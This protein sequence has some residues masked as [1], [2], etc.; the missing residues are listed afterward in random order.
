MAQ[1]APAPGSGNEDFYDAEVVNADAVA[2]EVNPVADKSDVLRAIATLCFSH[3]VGKMLYPHV[4]GHFLKQALPQ[5]LLPASG[6]G[7]G[8]TS[9]QTRMNKRLGIKEVP[10]YKLDDLRQCT[11]YK[12]GFGTVYRNV[13][14]HP[15]SL[16]AQR[17]P[18]PS[19]TRAQAMEYEAVNLLKRHFLSPYND[20]R[21]THDQV[22]EDADASAAKKRKKVRHETLPPFIKLFDPYNFLRILV[23]DPFADAVQAK[24]LGPHTALISGLH[25]LDLGCAI[26]ESIK[27]TDDIPAGHWEREVLLQGNQTFV[28]S[29]EPLVEI[30]RGLYALEFQLQ[31]EALSRP[32]PRPTMRLPSQINNMHSYFKLGPPRM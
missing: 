11:K 3:T 15:P 31:P 7:G 32:A 5:E 30:Q 2:V 25:V 14:I 9:V 16:E 21:W 17:D 22:V 13:E 23:V 6:N 18:G 1:P 20:F 26:P 28:V 19:A 29:Q 24:I 4:I 27:T 12:S 8:D 10:G